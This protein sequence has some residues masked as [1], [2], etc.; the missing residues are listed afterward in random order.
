MNIAVTTDAAKIRSVI[1]LQS[2]VYSV[3]DQIN[4][5]LKKHFYNQ[6]ETPHGLKTLNAMGEIKLHQKENFARGPLQR[7]IGF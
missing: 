6:F 2:V 3:K 1:V 5:N 7:M 4:A